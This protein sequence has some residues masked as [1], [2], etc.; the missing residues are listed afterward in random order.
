[1]SLHT[2]LQIFPPSSSIF[3]HDGLYRVRKWIVA[4]WFILPNVSAALAFAKAGAAYEAA[5]AFCTLPVRPYW[6]RLALS[7]VPRYL[8]WLFIMFV[9]IRIYR[10]L[11][12]EFRVFGWEEDRSNSLSM[13]GESPKCVTNAA[14]GALG[15]KRRKSG[16][17]DSMSGRKRPTPEDDVAPDDMSIRAIR[18]PGLPKPSPP[19]STNSPP[20]SRRPSAPDWSAAFGFP[21][22]PLNGP[23]SIN[24]NSSSRRGSRQVVTGVLVEDFAAPP[25]PHDPN[26]HRSSITT[27]NSVKSS[28]TQS[29]DD[30]PALAPILENKRDSSTTTTPSLQHQ[31]QQSH[32]HAHQQ[33][34]DAATAALQLRRRAI[35]RQLRLLFIYPLVYMILWALPFAAHAMNYNDHFAQHPSFPLQALNIFC[36]CF[37]G[38]VD[39]TVFCWREKPWCHIPGSSGTFLGSF[40]FWRF[41]LGRRTALWW[42]R[43]REGL[44]WRESCAPG[45]GSEGVGD[46]KFDFTAAA[47]AAA[48][49]DHRNE[50]SQSRARLLTSLKRWSLSIRTS[51]P[52]GSDVSGAATVAAAAPV[53]AQRV[54]PVVHRRVRSGG[55]DRRHLEAE[56]AHE[57]LVAERADYERQRRSLQGRRSSVMEVGIGSGSSPPREERRKEWWDREVEEDLGVGESV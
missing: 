8:I 47:A 19:D 17:I 15:E 7:W 46:E 28:G 43:R 18:S 54:R 27:L 34:P 20:Q 2:W 33:P 45:Y 24:S 11:G 36:Q 4:I 53:V 49:D 35:Q 39:V 16:L 22:E 31:P 56:R 41:C 57:R 3:G 10:H 50:K 21:N 14:A 29:N 25:S 38:T 26:R 40:C 32:Q 9:A 23:Q 13:L 52:R 5:G 37:L 42:R 12:K 1:M 51:S 44:Q 6:Y 55:S 48:V 30:G